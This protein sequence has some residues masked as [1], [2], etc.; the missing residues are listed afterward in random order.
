MNRSSTARSTGSSGWSEDYFNG[1]ATTESFEEEFYKGL[2]LGTYGYT[3]WNL[4]RPQ[5]KDIAVRKAIAMAFDFEG[6]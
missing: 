1:Q 3:G 6:Y 2:Y 4:Y 5:L